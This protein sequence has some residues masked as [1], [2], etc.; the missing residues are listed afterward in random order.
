MTKKKFA[1]VLFILASTI[2]LAGCTS[3]PP[4]V[5]SEPVG[6]APRSVVAMERR[7]TL[8][9]YSDWDHFATG[10][11]DRYYRE[12]YTLYWPD[13][14]RTQRVQN[15]I[16]SLD[17]GPVLLRLPPGT[18]RVKTRAARYG[19][20]I[21]TVVIEAERTTAI[22]LDG[23]MPKRAAASDASEVRLPNGQVVGWKASR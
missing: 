11:S 5:L 16:G 6:P 13:S 17:E 21:V 1:P 14:T 18:Y 9:V 4:L 10:D 7:G 20:V 8:V 3:T 19:T 2:L 22:R 15:H 23:T 12:D